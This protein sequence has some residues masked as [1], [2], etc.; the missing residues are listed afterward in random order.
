VYRDISIALDPTRSLYNGAPSTLVSWIDALGLREGDE[1]FHIGA[2][3]GY[4][5]AVIAEVVGPR[6]RVLAAEIDETL[7]VQARTNLS[8]YRHVEVVITDGASYDPGGC[9]AILVNAGVTHPSKFW[10]DRLKLEGRLVLPLTFEFPNTHLG[11]GALLRI[12]KEQDGFSA[13][14]MPQPVVIFS[15][16]NNRDA[17]LNAELFAAFTA[18]AALM[19]E[20]RSLRLDLHDAEPTC[21]V[22]AGLICLSCNPVRSAKEDGGR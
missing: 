3:T 22:H 6:G 15:C 16:T 18:R 4:Y 14:F 2:G 5:T 13:A 9:D 17:A 12:R 1:V 21:W 7:G 20:V 11:K 8:D 10:T 19:R